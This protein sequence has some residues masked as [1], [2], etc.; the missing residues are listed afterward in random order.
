[1]E[2]SNH[3]RY[4]P[5]KNRPQAVLVFSSPLHLLE[6]HSRL[7]AVAAAETGAVTGGGGDGVEAIA[8]GGL[9]VDHRLQLPEVF[10]GCAEEFLLQRDLQNNVL[11]HKI[12]LLGSEI[13][14]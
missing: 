2:I 7:N 4:F 6:Y 1:M 5:P 3:L 8:F 11:R 10:G 14:L 12:A 13:I 9:V